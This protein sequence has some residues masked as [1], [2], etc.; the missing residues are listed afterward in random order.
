[1]KV[2]M[3]KTRSYQS[4]KGRRGQ[5]PWKRGKMPKTACDCAQTPSALNG[6]GGGEKLEKVVEAVQ[7]DG[8]RGKGH[9]ASLFHE[10]QG[11]V[12]P[13]KTHGKGET[14]QRKLEGPGGRV[15]TVGN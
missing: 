5:R 15:T 9:K 14:A 6:N 1:V 10:P 12:P 11:K 13:R 8:T 2:Q 3:P 4:G 7:I